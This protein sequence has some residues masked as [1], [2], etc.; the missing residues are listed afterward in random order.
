MI[1]SWILGLSLLL[2]GSAVPALTGRVVDL[3]DVLSPDE[4]RRLTSRLET[5]ERETSTQIVIG[6]VPSLEGESI[7]DYTFRVAE[8]WQIGQAGRDNGIV[9]LVAVEDRRVRIEVGYG[10]EAVIPD[11]LAG[12]IIRERITPAFRRGDYYGGLNAAIEGLELAARQEYPPESAQPRGRMRP[13]ISLGGLFLVFFL[14]GI[15]GNA[16][17]AFA[18]A[19]L[20]AF[21]GLVFTGFAWWGVP[22][23]AVLGLVAMSLFRAGPGGGAGG[24]TYHPTSGGGWS[25][26]GGGFGGG[27]FSGGGGGFGG[28]GASGSW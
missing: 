25:G 10:L 26:G 4:E 3:G 15:I 16:M 24:W 28:G 1:G 20:G 21:F 2:Q 23:G 18:A 5:L 8:S 14:S 7:E 13:G 17:G 6:I 11:G 9:L 19:I 12:R 22:L 27:G